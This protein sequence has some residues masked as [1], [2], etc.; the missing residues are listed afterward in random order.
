MQ[1]KPVEVEKEEK[2]DVPYDPNNPLMRAPYV[3]GGLINDLK[4]RAPH[5]LSDFKDGLD[6]QVL[7][8][9]IFIYFAALSGAIAFGGLLGEKTGGLIGISETM[10][11]SSISGI[12]FS[13]FAGMP[14]IIT[15]K[16]FLNQ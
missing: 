15:G 14:I 11:F 7:A 12:L 1:K 4:R 13:L 6:A 8:A 5:Y 16:I 10:L 9:A 3:F 2:K